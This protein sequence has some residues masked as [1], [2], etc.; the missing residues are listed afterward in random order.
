[1]SGREWWNEGVYDYDGNHFTESY[2]LG[3]YE[4]LDNAKDA[5]KQCVKAAVEHVA[6]TF[7]LGDTSTIQ[8]LFNDDGKCRCVS[9]RLWI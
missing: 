9:L 3:V 1:M 4:N 6:E 7:I 8:S 5:L 2:T